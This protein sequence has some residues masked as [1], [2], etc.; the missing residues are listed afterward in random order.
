MIKWGPVPSSTFS[1]KYDTSV[2]ET[3]IN[4]HK[5]LSSYLNQVEG[6]YICGSFLQLN[7]SWLIKQT[8]ECLL[9]CTL[10]KYPTGEN[11]SWHFSKVYIANN[12]WINYL[13]LLTVEKSNL[14]EIWLLRPIQ[15]RD[16]NISIQ[17]GLIW[18]QFDH[19]MKPERETDKK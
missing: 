16:W 5:S 14:Y 4:H 2:L 13:I 15:K 18:Q 3:I 19:Q 17:Y 12:L 11:F 9:I 10:R 6:C 1:H 8:T 7:C